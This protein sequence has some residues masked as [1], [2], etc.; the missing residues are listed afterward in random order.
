MDELIKFLNEKVS[1][2]KKLSEELTNESSIDLMFDKVKDEYK[3]KYR[4]I[5]TD[6]EEMANDLGDPEENDD[7]LTVSD[8]AKYLMDNEERHSK[9]LYLNVK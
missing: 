7:K 3:Q 6:Y 5:V 9:W 1:E 2:L 4:S 8:K